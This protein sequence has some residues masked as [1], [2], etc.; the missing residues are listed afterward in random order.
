MSRKMVD[1]AK[2][3]K[4]GDIP[5]KWK[6][7]NKKHKFKV[8][9][10][11]DGVVERR[12][13]GWWAHPSTLIGAGHKPTFQANT[14][15]RG[16]SRALGYPYQ[17]HHVIPCAVFKKLKKIKANLKLLG[18]DINDEGLNGISLPS[19]PKDIKWH[20]IQAHRGS[21]GDYNDKVQEYL[22]NLEGEV[23]DFCKEDEQGELWEEIEDAVKHFRK[24]ILTWKLPTLRSNGVNER[25]AAAQA[26]ANS[27][28]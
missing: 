5:C 19:Q 12:A 15:T 7:C 20:D 23:K 14:S 17:K 3:G 24:H 18:F 9:Y 28:L 2:G 4:G 13:L 10:P 21:H 8:P 27:H 1:F 22:T 26:A 25:I 11:N 16:G 6:V